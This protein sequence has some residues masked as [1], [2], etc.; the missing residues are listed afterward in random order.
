MFKNSK[1]LLIVCIFIAQNTN[2]QTS[3][4][5]ASYYAQKFEGR[6]CASGEIF[7]HDSLTCAHKN[8][9]FGTVLKICNHKNKCVTVKVNDRLPQ[10]S[11]RTVDLTMRAAKEIDLN[12]AGLLKVDIEIIGKDSIYSKPQKY[13]KGKK[14]KKRKKTTTKKKHG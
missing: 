6:R 8:L 2:A 10:N 13:V 7:R 3:K 14:Q 9:P 5:I 4:G 11:K 1:L 12:Y